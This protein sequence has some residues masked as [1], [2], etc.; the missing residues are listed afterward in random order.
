MTMSHATA[1]NVTNA[2]A[3]AIAAHVM[4]VKMKL[5]RGNEE[6]KMATKKYELL[7]DDTKTVNSRKLYRIKALVAIG[8][9]VAAGDVGG[10]VHWQIMKKLAR[11][12]FDSGEWL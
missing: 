5:T 7:Q 6:K 1:A 2:M 3:S 12:A 11:Q 10:Y 4:T 8:L 9:S